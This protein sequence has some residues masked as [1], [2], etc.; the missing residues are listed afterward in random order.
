MK[1]IEELDEL[2]ERLGDLE[3]KMAELTLEELDE[4]LDCGNEARD[5]KQ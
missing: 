1:P 3:E 4:V 2:K 5:S